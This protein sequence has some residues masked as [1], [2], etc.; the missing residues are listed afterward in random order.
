MFL[1]FFPLN[2]RSKEQ[3]IR[4]AGAFVF[5]KKRGVGEGS[6][7]QNLRCNNDERER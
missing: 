6:V 1:F 5:A 2:R 4:G 3:K 7:L